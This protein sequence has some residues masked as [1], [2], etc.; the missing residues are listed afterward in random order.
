MTA[1]GCQIDGMA[2]AIIIATATI[3]TGTG[4]TGKRSFSAL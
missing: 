1:D 3:I 2:I 4:V